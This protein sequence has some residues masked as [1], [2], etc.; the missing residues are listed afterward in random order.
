MCGRHAQRIIQIDDNTFLF[1]IQ[2]FLPLLRTSIPFLLAFI[3]N[4]MFLT[5]DMQKSRSRRGSVSSTNRFPAEVLCRI[6]ADYLLDSDAVALD[7]TDLRLVCRFWNDIVISNPS[8]WTCIVVPTANL[9]WYSSDKPDAVFAG[10]SLA[11]QRSKNLPIE[12]I[13]VFPAAKNYSNSFTN[14][15]IPILCDLLAPHWS[16]TIR[17]QVAGANPELQE[18]FGTAS[19]VCACPCF[20]SSSISFS[21]TLREQY[22]SARPTTTQLTSLLSL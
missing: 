8:L 17:L 22:T 10:T 2:P 7:R 11:L 3:P 21:K 18:I 9:P 4:P 19:E 6:F 14:Q 12:V 15:H 20:A 1:R 13:I 16:R 5:S